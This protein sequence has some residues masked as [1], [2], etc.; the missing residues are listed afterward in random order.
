M[1]MS[2]FSLCSTKTLLKIIDSS[3]DFLTIYM[4][5]QELENRVQNAKSQMKLQG[6]IIINSKTVIKPTNFK[7]RMEKV[8]KLDTIP[9]FNVISN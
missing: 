9:E 6:F 4:C 5:E 7:T 2:S 3:D 8:S 1:S